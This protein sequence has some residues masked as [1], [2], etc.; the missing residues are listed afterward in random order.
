MTKLYRRNNVAVSPAWQAKLD[1][2]ITV[3]DYNR[4]ISKKVTLEEVLK[5]Y[6]QEPEYP[7]YEQAYIDNKITYQELTNIELGNVSY[8]R[9]KK[10]KSYMNCYAKK[11]GLQLDG[12]ELDTKYDAT[13]IANEFDKYA[14]YHTGKL[15]SLCRRTARYIYEY[16]GACYTDKYYNYAEGAI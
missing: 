7:D 12:Y 2:K 5:S 6:E 15:A 3:E 16:I 13:F 9:T 4:I 11:I 10:I 8:Q 14:D 1:G